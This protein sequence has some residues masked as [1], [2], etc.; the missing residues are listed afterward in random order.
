M[1]YLQ[2]IG[3]ITLITIMVQNKID[4]STNGLNFGIYL[5]AVIFALIG[6]IVEERDNND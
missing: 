2:T 6:A 1:N 3:M 5:V 4:P